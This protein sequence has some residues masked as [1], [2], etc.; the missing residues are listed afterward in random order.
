MRY[1]GRSPQSFFTIITPSIVRL[2]MPNLRFDEQ[3]LRPKNGRETQPEAGRQSKKLFQHVFF[4]QLFF[5]RA[6][7]QQKFFRR[8]QKQIFSICAFLTEA[9]RIQEKCEKNTLTPASAMPT[10][11]VSVYIHASEQKPAKFYG[12]VDIEVEGD[13]RNNVAAKSFVAMVLKWM[14]KNKVVKGEIEPIRL[15][16]KLHEDAGGFPITPIDTLGQCPRMIVT[17]KTFGTTEKMERE[18][19]ELLEQVKNSVN[20]Q[21]RSTSSSSHDLISLAV[22]H[23]YDNHKDKS[24]FR[25]SA[26]TTI[27]TLE[28][29]MR[30]QLYD[31]SKKDQP[32]FITMV[33]PFG[34]PTG[35]NEDHMVITE[36]AEMMNAIETV[37]QA[38]YEEGLQEGEIRSRVAQQLQPVQPPPSAEPEQSGGYSAFSGLGMKLGEETPR[39]KSSV[40]VADEFATP[41]SAPDEADG[42][43]ETERGMLFELNEKKDDSMKHMV[44]QVDGIPL[45]KF[46]YH[47]GQRFEV[48]FQALGETGLKTSHRNNE[49]ADYVLHCPP[50]PSIAHGYDEIWGGDKAVFVL[51]SRKK[52]ELKMASRSASSSGHQ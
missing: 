22:I 29:K 2:P 26:T 41:L 43:W 35:Y 38:A 37:R 36:R 15:F 19:V 45:Y 40:P 27:G 16:M 6:S 4:G 34:A 13:E 51:D 9:I 3:T 44:I 20:L 1:V 31:P 12:R 30:E 11:D 18:Q 23:P 52:H 25:V 32:K 10:F 42:L 7:F 46:Y 5:S 48:V 47:D 8:S 50:L 14:K 49:F 21:E 39:E 17:Y 33:V 24:L 28:E